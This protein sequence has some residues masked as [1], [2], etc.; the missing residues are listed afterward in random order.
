M[1]ATLAQILAAIGE[2]IV[3]VLVAP[4]GL[5]VTVSGAAIVDPEDDPTDQPGRLVLLI[6]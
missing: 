3:D 6:G 5:D 1:D 4:S 2:P